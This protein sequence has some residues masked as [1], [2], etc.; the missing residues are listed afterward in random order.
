M[1]LPGDGPAPHV[2]M[3][4][5]SG[6]ERDARVRKTALAVAEAGYRVTLVWGDH[7]GRKTVEGHLG[8]VRTIGVPVPYLLRDA[9]ALRTARRREWRPQ[10]PG[11][12]S[13]VA[14]QTADTSIRAASTRA[15]ARPRV[16]VVRLR[17][18]VH[19]A[20][21]RLFEIQEREFLRVWNRLDRRRLGRLPRIDWRR[22]LANVAD[23]EAAFTRLLW[24]LEP[25][26]LHVH[27]IHLLGA[28]AQAKRVCAKHGRPAALVYDAHEFVSGLSGRD[29]IVEAAYAAMEGALIGRADAV[30][31]VSEPIADA[32]KARYDLPRRPTVVLNTPTS[33]PPRPASGDVRSAAGVGPDALLL[34]YAGGVGRQRNVSVVLRALSLLPSAH[35][36]VICVPDTQ[37]HAARMLASAAVEEGV[38]GRVHLLEPVPPEEIVDFLATAD[39]G[40][41]PMLAGIPNHEM[42]LPNKL[43]DYIF[44]GLPV[45]VSATSEMRRFVQEEKVGETFDPEDPADV[46]RAV[47]A[48]VEGRDS[49]RARTKDDALRRTYSWQAQAEK[50]V[51]LYADLP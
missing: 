6:I 1:G 13:R 34:V 49:F 23:L 33:E 5:A 44:A 48:V 42:A 41:H 14:L 51:T 37:H 43:F 12:R 7:L 19:G 30:I 38:E 46:A 39:I 21:S 17:Q 31:T 45:A 18:I 2:V 22:E 4:V 3:A 8:A 27:D 36:A 40:V 20:R 11:Y 47:L 24:Q 28:G 9:R 25:D 32:L 16:A 10:W 29:R 50:L 26:I 35:L 15:G